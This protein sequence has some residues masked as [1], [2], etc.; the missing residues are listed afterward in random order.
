LQVVPLLM[1][2]EV[3]MLGEVIDFKME[4]IVCN[5]LV[6]EKLGH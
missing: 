5:M 6:G 3:N 4:G 1:Y 2:I